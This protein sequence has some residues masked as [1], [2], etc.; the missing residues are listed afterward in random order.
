MTHRQFVYQKSSTSSD[1]DTHFA[2]IPSNINNVNDYVNAQIEVEPSLD[3]I[4]AFHINDL[5]LELADLGLTE[6]F[7]LQMFEIQS[8]VADSSFNLPK[9]E[10]NYTRFA[11]TVANLG[12]M[13]P[14]A[15]REYVESLSLGT[16]D[17]ITECA[18]FLH[19][20]GVR[21]IVLI[22]PEAQEAYT[23]SSSYH[24]FFREINGHLTLGEHEKLALKH[25]LPAISS[26][27]PTSSKDIIRFFQPKIFGITGVDAF[28]NAPIDVAAA[29]KKKK[30][31]S[32]TIKSSYALPFNYL[33]SGTTNPKHHREVVIS[34]AVQ[35]L[36][37]VIPVTQSSRIACST[38]IATYPGDFC[39]GINEKKE[40]T[41][42]KID[43]FMPI[44][45]APPGYKGD[46]LT[47]DILTQYQNPVD[48]EGSAFV[49]E[50]SF[51]EYESGS[52]IDHRRDAVSLNQYDESDRIP[53][54]ESQIW[55]A[56]LDTGKPVE[57]KD[58]GLWFMK[59][60]YKTISASNWLAG[61]LYCSVMN[62]ADITTLFET[63]YNR[64][65]HYHVIN[66]CGVSQLFLVIHK[67]LVHNPTFV[68]SLATKKSEVK[69]NSM[70][71][72]PQYLSMW[73]GAMKRFPPTMSMFFASFVLEMHRNAGKFPEYIK[74][75]NSFTKA[76]GNNGSQT[77]VPTIKQ[78][79]RWFDRIWNQQSWGRSLCLVKAAKSTG[80]SLAIRALK[81]MSQTEIGYSLQDSQ[82]DDDEFELDESGITGFMDRFK[83][84]DNI[85]DDE[86]PP[87]DTLGTQQDFA[88]SQSDKDDENT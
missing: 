62:P 2:N 48:Y 31:A 84:F 35:D 23:L 15:R 75:K 50:E 21:G 11:K 13:T 25:M 22:D 47:T 17:S 55:E 37:G 26:I 83:S 71:K 49:V 20:T 86:E 41:S 38:G 79:L 28:I 59:M 80:A 45:L 12:M 8:I 69:R 78:A 7:L 46:S 57:C 63:A 16:V 3:D 81:V 29:L 30:L 58:A 32:G 44:Y 60:D 6:D 66:I 77:H 9:K 39:T 10:E 52:W 4:D 34:R 82:D 27:I 76:V 87:Q 40:F 85:Y 19:S 88:G 1:D 73:K 5:A 36:V 53:T 70:G 14:D 61:K 67:R 24:R 54:E 65:K 42:T 72:H 18:A 74:V 64:I 51:A 33:P 68:D 43:Y 56:V